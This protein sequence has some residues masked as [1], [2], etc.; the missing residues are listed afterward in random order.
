MKTVTI[1]AMDGF[2]LGAR[3]YA[4]RGAPRAQVVIHAATAAP[5]R[6][7]QAFGEH[8]AARGFR[9]LTYDYRGI[10]ASRRGSLRGFSAS[11]T[12]W[13]EQDARAVVRHAHA[14]APELPLLVVGHSF[15]GQIA[16][17]LPDEIRIAGAFMVGAQSGY[18]KGFD[19][20]DRGALWMLWNVVMPAVT[21]TW[22]YVPGWMGIG[23]DLPAGVAREW[24]R[25][26]STPGYFLREHPEYGTRMRSHH[27]PVMV[28]SFSDDEY[29]PLR[30]ARWLIDQLQSARVE[31]RH[32][33]PSEVGLA[34]IGHFGFF[35][36]K[37]A[38]LWSLADEY[39]D[40]V[41][42]ASWHP[43]SSA[44]L[45]ETEIMADLEYGRA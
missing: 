32:L 39:F 30:N 28:L 8:L 37:S 45:R 19:W 2:E 7:Y 12:T 43:Q 21:K 27:G 33:V 13:A 16:L 17:A 26:C 4:P 34:S 15:G 14:S 18:W 23:E 42:D 3:V 20:P 41:L 11:M 36:R 5:Q 25:W 6:Y 9:V 40:A 31:H 22:G 10:G 38:I 1:E 44:W 24:A 29:V 35:R